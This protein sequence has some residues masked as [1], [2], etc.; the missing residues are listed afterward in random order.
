[1]HRLEVL[2]RL[3]RKVTVGDHHEIEVALV[4][5]EV[6]NGERAVKIHADEATVQNGSHS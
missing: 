1:M 6:A 2:E 5:L 4:G 3:G